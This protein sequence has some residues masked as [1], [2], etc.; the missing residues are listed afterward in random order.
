MNG[1]AAL[2]PLVA[3]SFK[4]GRF[5]QAGPG[6]L[7]KKQRGLAAPLRRFKGKLLIQN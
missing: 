7:L 3:A 2:R 1:M 5:I 4:P 6:A